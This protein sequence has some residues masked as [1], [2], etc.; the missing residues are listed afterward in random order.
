MSDKKEGKKKKGEGKKKWKCKKHKIAKHD[1]FIN[2]RV[3]TD[4]DLAVKLF[5]ALSAETKEDGKA[6]RPFLDVECLND[7]EEW[8]AGFLNGLESAA[9][10]LLLISEDGIKG[11]EGAHER[12]DNVLL[13]Y[14]YALDKHG[15]ETAVLLPLVV[16]KTVEGGLYK[17]FGAFGV[18]Q[19]SD[20]KHASG[21]ST[22]TSVR[23]TME[24]LFKI[25]GLK[26]DPNAFGD[27]IKDITG[28][29][30][31]ALKKFG[32]MG[33]K[34]EEET[35]QDKWT[36]TW[37]VKDV[38]SYLKDAG[39]EEFQAKFKENAVDG[40]LFMAL[41]EKMLTEELGVTKKLHVLKILKYI[42]EQKKAEAEEEDEEEDDGEEDDGEEE[43]DGGK[44]KKG[45]DDEEEGEE[46]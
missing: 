18:S 39:L 9:V 25:Q 41:D 32:R 16:G 37:T 42:E 21:K 46:E 22:G 14:E 45:G 11:I 24:Q 30:D 29:I 27:R 43:E 5:Y 8:E 26:T 36:S 15:K 44:K 31:E 3:R 19:Y 2:Y 1:V 20:Q 38:Q 17:P 13:E 12:Q 10:M 23:A 6:I 35:Y 4:K 7:G 34:K 28:K 33:E 40:T